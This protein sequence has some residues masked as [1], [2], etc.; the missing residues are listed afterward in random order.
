MDHFNDPR[1][2][3]DKKADEGMPRGWAVM[4]A[5]AVVLVVVGATAGALR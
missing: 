3:I 5:L 4:L 1:R 2:S